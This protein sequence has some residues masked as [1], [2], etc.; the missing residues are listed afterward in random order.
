L[1]VHPP[2]APLVRSASTP[3]RTGGAARLPM[4]VTQLTPPALVSVATGGTG[5]GDVTTPGSPGLAAAASL[6][7]DPNVPPPPPSPSS[8]GPSLL[9]W[10]ET[11]S[12]ATDFAA[13]SPTPGV[14]V[15]QSV[16][17]VGAPPIPGSLAARGPDQRPD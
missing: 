4:R 5:G 8:P 2:V 14:A 10:L 1:P 12:G 7:H 3:A 13:M 16:R 9:R 17:Y 15:P 6:P 11:T